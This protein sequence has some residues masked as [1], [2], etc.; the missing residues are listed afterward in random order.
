MLIDHK[1]LLAM[2]ACELDEARTDLE[3]LGVALCQDAT[4]TTAHVAKLQ[5]LDHIG[6]RCASVADILRS[7][8]IYAAS[9]AAPLESIANRLESLTR[10]A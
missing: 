2:L 5:A 9:A 8:D 6:Q 4:I 1:A 7:P 10:Q 3:T